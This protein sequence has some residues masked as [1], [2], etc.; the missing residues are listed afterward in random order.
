VLSPEPF[1]L[2]QIYTK[3]FSGWGDHCSAPTD[4]LASKGEGRR[5]REGREDEGGEG[6]GREVKSGY[7]LGCTE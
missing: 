7:T 5:G 3:L 2:A 6:K 1:F 4:L